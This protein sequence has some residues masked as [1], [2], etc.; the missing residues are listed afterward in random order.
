M[1]GR[2]SSL[3]AVMAVATLGAVAP[4]VARAADRAGERFGDVGHIAAKIDQFVG[5]H[6]S[7]LGV[8]SAALSADAEFLRRVMLDLAGRVPTEKEARGFVADGSSDK[9]NQAVRRLIEGPEFALHFGRVLDGLIQQDK[10]GNREFVE[11]LRTAVREDR[12]WDEIYRSVLV[13]PWDEPKQQPAARFLSDRVKSADE[14]TADSGRAFFGVDISCARCHDHPHV[15]DWKQRNYFGMV[16]FFKPTQ[17]TKG[18]GKGRVS[19]LETDDREVK[20]RDTEGKEHVAR[21]TFLSG[22]EFDSKGGARETLVRES[23]A[24]PVFFRRAIVNQIWSY[25]FGRGL[26]DPVDQ[27]HSANPPAVAGLLE[28]LGNDLAEHGYDLKRLVAGIVSSRAYQLTSAWPSDRPRPDESAFAVAK[29]RPLSPE[30]LALSLILVTGGDALGDGDPQERERKYCDL[31]RRASALVEK[32][33]LDRRENG[34]QASVSEAMFMSNH[35]DVQKLFEPFSGNSS[36]NLAHRLIDMKT[37]DDGAVIE[38]AVWGVLSRAPEPD[39]QQT[40][41]NWLRDRGRQRREAITRLIWS[42]ATS[43]EFRFNH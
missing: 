14:M 38:A 19:L 9:R 16:S 30:Q 13:G 3:I 28:W 32:R 4:A 27:M 34:Y 2:R 25:L 23:L 43:S 5:Q 37:T 17:L 42:L 39:E 20:F 41:A 31:E 35:P 8:E 26:V 40:L 22:K 1:F 33:F 10:A 12:G 6:W 11:Y 7:S 24:D 18:K 29:V 15:E 21:P 36:G